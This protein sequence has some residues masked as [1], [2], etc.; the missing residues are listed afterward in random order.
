M[1]N[2]YKRYEVVTTYIEMETVFSGTHQECMIYL[3]ERALKNGNV[4]S[5]GNPFMRIW[6]ENDGWER[7]DVGESQIFAIKPVDKEP[8]PHVTQ[9]QTDDFWGS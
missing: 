8:A 6:T 3:R 1:E 2:K 7:V 4:S 9:R 5:S